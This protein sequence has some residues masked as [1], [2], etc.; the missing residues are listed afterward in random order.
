M[1]AILLS[2][3]LIAQQKATVNIDFLNHLKGQKLEQERL[4]YYQHIDLLESKKEGF[5]H[6][7][8][9]LSAKYR[10]S[11]LIKQYQY[12]ANDTND[13]MMVFYTGI[14]L[15][16]RSLCE[17]IYDELTHNNLSSKQRLLLHEIMEFSKDNINIDT[18]SE[19]FCATT[20]Q[21]TKLQNKNIYV[22]MG[23]SMLLPGAGKYY[24]MQSNEATG[25]LVLNLI[26]AAP[27][28]EIVFRFGLISAGVV[29]SGLVFIP[30]YI[31]NIY[32]TVRSKKVLLKKL[33]TQLKNEVLDYCAF[34]LHH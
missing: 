23:L 17:Q 22:A 9:Y 19:A 15:N 4:A 3:P 14:L 24:L 27:V 2:I 7:I 30:V 18:L 32:G 6:D 25:T 28:A 21:I 1:F 33:K 16:T 11:I 31:A 8:C 12:F 20:N 26:A 13:L 34:Q 29:F 10:D 5:T